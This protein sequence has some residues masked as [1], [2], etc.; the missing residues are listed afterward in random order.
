M[1]NS[2]IQRGILILLLCG[3]PLPAQQKKNIEV[4]DSLV[5][6]LFDQAEGP[7]SA[8]AGDTMYL[9]I[10]G[11]AG[12]YVNYLAVRLGNYF[13]EKHFVVFRNN[14]P[15][16][17]FDGIILIINN[18]TGGIEYSPPYSKRFLGTRFVRREVT[19][20][21]QGQILKG[22]RREITAAIDRT[23]KFQDEVPAARLTELESP[24]FPFTTGQPQGYSRWTAVVEPILAVTVVSVI[25]YLFYVQR[26]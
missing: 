23:E 2:R 11:A 10:E 21:I 3:C 15:A 6:A 4:M 16:I 17:S 18:F 19:V 13:R 25:I 22:K 26:G 7:L 14:E 9:V 5:T 1:M 24:G 8:A 12:T 20:K